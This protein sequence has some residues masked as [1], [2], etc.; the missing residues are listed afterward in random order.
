MRKLDSLEAF[1]GIAALSVA[2]YH[3]CEFTIWHDNSVIDNFYLFVDFF[4][5]LSGFIMAY[6]HRERIVDGM[7]TA[8]FVVLRLARLYPVHIFMLAAFLGLEAFKLILDGFGALP[9]RSPPFSAERVSG[10]SFAANLV[11]TQAFGQFEKLTWNETSWS[12]SIEFYLYIVFALICLAGILQTWLGR[13]CL[14]LSVA[15]VLA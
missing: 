2:I 3:W 15:G 6:V 10:E 8:R 1:R 12:I 4:F 14:A 5:V 11:L 9:L 7:S 13:A